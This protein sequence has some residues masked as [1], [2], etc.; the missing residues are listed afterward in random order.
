MSASEN[1]IDAKEPAMS[2]LS[3]LSHP[4]AA[5][6]PGRALAGH[7]KLPAGRVLSL[8]PRERSVLEITLGRVWL[9]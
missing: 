6:T 3:P 9:T 1:F 5:P 7:W 2:S 8:Y 4:T